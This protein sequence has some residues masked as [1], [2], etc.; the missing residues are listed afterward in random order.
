M[1][2]RVRVKTNAVFLQL[3]MGELIF[4]VEVKDLDTGRELVEGIGEHGVDYYLF[5]EGGQ[6]NIEE[7]HFTSSQEDI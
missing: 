6:G 3:Q 7:G 1:S 2:R 4:E 5:I